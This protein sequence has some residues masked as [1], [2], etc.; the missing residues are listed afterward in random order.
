MFLS[1]TIQN[2]KKERSFSNAGHSANGALQLPAVPP[3][4]MN[5][6][7]TKTI[8][9]HSLFSTTANSGKVLQRAPINTEWGTFTDEKYTVVEDNVKKGVDMLLSFLP[10][11]KVDAVDIG[12]TQ[13]IKTMSEGTPYAIGETRGEKERNASLKVGSGESDNDE[14]LGW[15]IDRGGD[16]PNPIY[17][18]D[19]PDPTGLGVG[20]YKPGEN[21]KRN[22]SSTSFENQEKGFSQMGH[23]KSGDNPVPAKLADTPTLGVPLKPNAGQEFETTALAI[24]GTQAGT[25]FGSVRWGWKTDGEG[26][27]SKIEFT[28]VTDGVPSKAFIAGAK[29]WN[30][31]YSKFTNPGPAFIKPTPLEA[32]KNIPLPIPE[33][34]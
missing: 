9:H 29:K 14:H 34:K 10:G 20:E 15:A 6:P 30:N 17:G 4:Q 22:L 26:T 13:V 33:D 11:E 25:Y 23:A 31:A 27:F 16:N 12:L 2:L 8:D 3:V 7:K 1:Q 5:N 28:K 24:N 21:T 32:Y 19:S 18:S